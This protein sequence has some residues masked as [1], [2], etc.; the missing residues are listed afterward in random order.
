MLLSFVPVLLSVCVVALVPLSRLVRPRA[1]AV[2]ADLLMQ[3]DLWGL[4]LKSLY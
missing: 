3:F 4:I 1:M 2:L